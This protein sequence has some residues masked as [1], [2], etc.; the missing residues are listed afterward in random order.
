VD[1]F[2]SGWVVRPDPEEQLVD[3]CPCQVENNFSVYKFLEVRRKV[4][5]TL[6]FFE[7]R[8]YTNNII[9]YG[10]GDN[11]FQVSSK[12][13]PPPPVSNAHPLRLP[14]SDCL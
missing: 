2:V 10:L 11:S 12:T 3:V 13:S 7:P 14:L 6:N 8:V 4:S 9:L 5:T 1:L